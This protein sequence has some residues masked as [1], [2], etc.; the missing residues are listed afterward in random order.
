MGDTRRN[1]ENCGGNER[2]SGENEVR[3][4]R[5]ELPTLLVRLDLGVKTVQDT[6]GCHD[7]EL[8]SEEQS[9][10]R[11]SPRNGSFFFR[12]PSQQ[13][14]S[15][16][17]SVKLERSI[18]PPLPQRPPASAPV[19][20]LP[21]PPSLPPPFVKPSL[22]SGLPD[23][24][25]HSLLRRWNK[26]IHHLRSTT[27][28]L[29]PDRL[30]LNPAKDETWHP[31]VLRSNVERCYLGIVC[32]VMEFVKQVARVRSWD[33]PLRTGAWCSVSLALSG[34]VAAALLPHN[35]PVDGAACGSRF[36]TTFFANPLCACYST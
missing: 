12:H 26:Q 16:E 25:L 15:E 4:G 17:V 33:D 23:Q 30:D 9:G 1:S 24:H 3:E 7:R 14:S 13:V 20:S 21:P 29:P 28:T 8:S 11:R 32:D 5:Y 18:P 6:F 31:D 2:W 10:E 36:M 22:V 27:S 35:R 19:A 34:G